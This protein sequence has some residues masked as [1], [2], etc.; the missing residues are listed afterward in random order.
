V[1]ATIKMIQNLLIGRSTDF[2][3]LEQYFKGGKPLTLS[4]CGQSF[5]LCLTLL[6]AYIMFYLIFPGNTATISLLGRWKIQTLDT[7][8]G[9]N[10]VYCF[11][12]YNCLCYCGTCRVEMATWRFPNALKRM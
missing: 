10:Y 3:E 6:M 12:V 7:R 2:R 11:F 4:V 1:A 8:H 9:Q 5:N